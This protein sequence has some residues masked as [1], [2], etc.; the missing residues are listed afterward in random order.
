M[1]ALFLPTALATV[2]YRHP[3]SHGWILSEALVP[4]GTSVVFTVVVREQGVDSIKRLATDISNP[5]SETYGE[6]PQ[7]VLNPHRVLN[8]QRVHTAF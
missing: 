3:Y 6:N 4:P 7:R 2:V 5:G 8:P 1:F